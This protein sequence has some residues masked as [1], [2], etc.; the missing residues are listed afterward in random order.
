MKQHGRSPSALGFLL[1]S[2]V[3]GVIGRLLPFRFHHVP[4]TEVITDLLTALS[5]KPLQIEG[6]LS[7]LVAG[8]RDRFLSND[9]LPPCDKL[10][11]HLLS[12]RGFDHFPSLEGVT[13]GPRHGQGL[14]L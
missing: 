10:Q 7:K 6:G 5:C 1:L 4:A 3:V 2:Y 11:S 14:P 12:F 9:Y 13:L 8:D